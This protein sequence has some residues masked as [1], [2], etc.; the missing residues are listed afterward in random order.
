M[1]SSGRLIG[2]NTAIY[3]PSG[4]SAGIGFAVP[5]IEINRVVP[6]II[7][8]GKVIRPGMGIT[9]ANKSINDRLGI[10]GA[11][12]LNVQSGSAAETAGLRET[13][14]VIGGIILGDIIIAVDGNKVDDYD[15]LRDELDLFKVGDTV[16]LIIIRDEQ[17][18]EIQVKLEEIS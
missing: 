9:L 18:M 2:V 1:D 17:P 16:T 10:K 7:R 12:I 5:V 15:E 8:Y 11:L 4:A 6:Q 14:Q 3:S 13:R